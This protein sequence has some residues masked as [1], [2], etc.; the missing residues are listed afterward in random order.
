MLYF[1]IMKERI[2]RYTSTREANLK[3]FVIEQKPSP[4][5]IAEFAYKNIISINGIIHLSQTYEDFL[6]TL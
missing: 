3:K 1:Y 4:S 5:Q 6:D 2:I